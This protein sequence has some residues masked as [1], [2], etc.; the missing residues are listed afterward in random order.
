MECRAGQGRIQ[1]VVS[2]KGRETPAK[3]QRRTTRAI[4]MRPI[5]DACL[6]VCQSHC[7]ESRIFSPKF[8]E[9]G[10]LKNR[11]L[12]SFSFRFLTDDAKDSTVCAQKCA[13]NGVPK[14]FVVTTSQLISCCLYLAPQA[15]VECE[16]LLTG[17]LSSASA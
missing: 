8:A 3:P 10:G 16:S 4:S 6:G 12:A 5:L 7:G 14:P 15:A 17:S 2:A 1:P 13:Q 9:S 11:R